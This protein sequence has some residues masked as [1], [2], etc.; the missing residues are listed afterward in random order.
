M[1]I[2]NWAQWP[3]SSDYVPG[4]G[5]TWGPLSVEGSY[6][7][8]SNANDA[9]NNFAPC[10]DH[11]SG[12]G[13]F[14]VVNGSTDAN[15][16]IWCQTVNISPNTDYLF[17]TW[18]ATMI[19]ENPAVLQFSINGQLLGTSFEA[20]L[21]TCEWQEFFETWNS[22]AST[23]AEICITNQNNDPSG[24]DFGL[25]D[26]ALEPICEAE[27]TI[28]IEV[29]D[30]MATISAVDPFCPGEQGEASV[31]VVDGQMPYTYSWSTG[32]M[33]DMAPLTTE[34]T[35]SVTVTDGIG[36]TTTAT[37]ELDISQPIVE[38]LETT[39]STCGDPNGSLTVLGQSGV[40][41]YL[42][43][44]NGVDF[45]N[46]TTFAGL[47]AGDYTVI[48][49]DTNGC[50]VEIA[51]TIATIEQVAV[52][53]VASPDVILCDD[54][55]ITLDAGD[56]ETYLW[57]DG[58]TEPTNIV[59]TEGMY[60]VTVTDAEGCTSVSIVGISVCVEEYTIE[61][62][63]AFTPDNDGRND[64]FGV[65]VTNGTVDVL[66]FQIYNRWGALVHD[67]PSNWD[68]N[69]EGK[70]HP[71]DILFYV[72][73]LSTPDGVEMRSGDVTLIR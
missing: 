23:T 22:G 69:Y 39:P 26:I 60:G 27:T 44:I 24:N 8:A 28:T 43:S 1:E 4:P 20:P 53:I 11:T 31:Q 30:P 33:T 17:S 10:T 52:A 9:H 42:F 19:S 16:N 72:I 34:G 29:S 2:L 7:I 32:D 3:Y 45:L 47:A 46:Q 73:E 15:A 71:S 63:S 61:M 58:S 25:D 65:V 59:T 67:A 51:T 35:Y 48:L 57:F 56:F 62:P 64:S 49:Q 37:Y 54:E 12:T 6:A 21:A 50:E 5:G 38:V 68:G 41:P 66:S 55:P 36:C 18:V 13:L 70:S 14:L 40:A